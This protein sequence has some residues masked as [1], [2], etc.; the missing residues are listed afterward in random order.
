LFANVNICS[1]LRASL[2]FNQQGRNEG[3]RGRN[4][5]CAESLWGRRNIVGAPK[6]I[7]NVTRTFFNMYICFRTTSD[8]KMGAPI[9]HRAPS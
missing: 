8:S 4:Y 1:F 5:L 7:N 9:L 6:N 3:A 2:G